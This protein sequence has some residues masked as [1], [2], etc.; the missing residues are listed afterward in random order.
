MPSLPSICAWKLLTCRGKLPAASILSNIPVGGLSSGER[1]CPQKAEGLSFLKGKATATSMALGHLN[2]YGTFDFRAISAI[3]YNKTYTWRVVLWNTFP[4]CSERTQNMTLLAW[5][6]T[7]ETKVFPENDLVLISPDFLF[8][9]KKSNAENWEFKC[10][11]WMKNV[12]NCMSKMY[13]CKV[14]FYCWT[15]TMLNSY[16]LPSRH[17]CTMYVDLMKHWCSWVCVAKLLPEAGLGFQARLLSHYLSS[18]P[19]GRK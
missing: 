3:I 14:D 12:E 15:P 18:G 7:S 1:T 19:I 2:S 17:L 8:P 5:L 11:N 10:Q 9:L 4:G 13:F 6:Q 16:S